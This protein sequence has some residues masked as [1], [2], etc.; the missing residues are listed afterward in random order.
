MTYFSFPRPLKVLWL[1]TGLSG[2]FWYLQTREPERYNL[3]LVVNL[4][5]RL[6]I[7]FA[8]LAFVGTI[9][10]MANSWEQQIHKKGKRPRVDVSLV[11]RH[12]G[13]TVFERRLPRRIWDVAQ[14]GDRLVK[15]RWSL[16]VRLRPR[17]R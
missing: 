5:H 10:Y 7:G 14:E 1:L 6:T 11:E 3:P 8:F 16:R 12:Y 4:G 13:G 9:G 17:H 2:V 15:E